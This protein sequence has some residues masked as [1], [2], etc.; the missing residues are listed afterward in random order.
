MLNFDFLPTS[1]E[2]PAH[3]A[4]GKGSFSLGVVDLSPLALWMVHVGRVPKEAAQNWEPTPPCNLRRDG[5]L[6]LTLKQYYETGLAVLCEWFG[7]LLTLF[8]KSFYI[9]LRSFARYQRLQ[10]SCCLIPD[11][12]QNYKCCRAILFPLLYQFI[13]STLYSCRCTS[14]FMRNRVNQVSNKDKKPLPINT[15]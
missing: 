6:F 13:L 5:C 9:H 1:L 2:N 12:I 7:F 4:M 3:P 14:A 11:I 10:M 8:P 15:H